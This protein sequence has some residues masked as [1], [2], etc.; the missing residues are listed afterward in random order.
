MLVRT[1]WDYWLMLLISSGTLFGFHWL[2]VTFLPMYDLR[3]RLNYIRRMPPFV[4]AMFGPDLLSITSMTAM[5]SFAYLHPVTLAI[6]M[7]IAIVLPS[8][9]LVGQI[10]RGTI[11]L[12]LSTPTSRK[13]IVSTTIIAGL[14][15]GAI[16]SA[17]ML[18][19]TW[20]GIQ[21]TK[22]PEPIVFKYTALIELNLFAL[23][24]LCMSV[25]IFV[26]SICS[27]RGTAV[28]LTMAFC[29][30]SY[31]VHF[32]S[33]WWKL[34]EKIAFLGP[35]YYFRPIKI[36]AGTY[37]PTQDILILLGVSAVLMIISTIWFSKRDIAVV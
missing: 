19:G 5:N 9:M 10:D 34:I 37:N 18:L 28:G 23:Y 11:E 24:V 35:I 26:S 32:L 8:W 21:N 29:V 7:A 22:L 3:L 2:A 17:S 14:I 16:L 1:W 25:S 13:K 36:A 27:L 4:K 12:T 15:A 33:E 20:V 6:L 30:G 31:L